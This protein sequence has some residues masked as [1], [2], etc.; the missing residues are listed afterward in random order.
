ML[1][2]SRGGWI[3]FVGSLL[4][5][6]VFSLKRRWH[7][8]FGGFLI[9]L[10]VIGSITLVIMMLF[11]N[12]IVKRLTKDDYGAAYSRIPLAQAA[13]VVIKENPI[14][15]IGLGN[16]RIVIEDYDPDP[17]LNE[18][19]TPFIV[20]NMFLLIASELGI[21]AFCLFMWVSVIFF[22]Q[23]IAVIASTDKV[24]SLYALGMLA[25]LAGF[26]LYSMLEPVD[27]GNTRLVLLFF[28]GGCLVGLKKMKMTEGRI[29]VV[30]TPTVG[31]ENKH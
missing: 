24:K 15:G 10:I 1:T 28:A 26:Y 19:G 16:Y 3:G 30:T 6:A 17:P 5:I 2:Y 18:I 31:E 4:V 20:H 13:L 29:P 9:R 22:R 12:Q 11:F 7:K 27:F 21:P 25:G 14:T 8:I 23:G